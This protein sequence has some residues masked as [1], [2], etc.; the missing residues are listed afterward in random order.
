M[1]RQ[2]KTKTVDRPVDQIPRPVP[3]VFYRTLG[4][5]RL[6][7]GTIVLDEDQAAARSSRL[8]FGGEGCYAIMDPTEFVAGEII[9][10]LSD[11]APPIAGLLEPVNG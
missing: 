2:R 7:S 4:I 9:G 8:Y 10:F 5:V 6:Y 11:P 1:A 3:A